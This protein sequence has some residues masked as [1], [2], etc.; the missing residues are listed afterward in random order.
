MI[1]NEFGCREKSRVSRE[2]G[3]KDVKPFNA[4]GLATSR[5]VQLKI[6]ESCDFKNLIYNAKHCVIISFQW[7]LPPVTPGVFAEKMVW[8]TKN[9]ANHRVTRDK[10]RVGKFTECGNQ[11][12]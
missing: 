12:R 1:F 2:T 10:T 8:K 4:D 3:P 9:L 5:N 7:N 6:M 11:D